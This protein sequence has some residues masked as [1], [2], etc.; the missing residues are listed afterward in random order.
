MTSPSSDRRNGLNSSMA[1]KVP[2]TAATTVNI[3]LNGEQTID[4][5]A[6]VAGTTCLV[7]DQSDPVENGIY[8][9]DTGDWT[10]RPDCDGPNDLTYGTIVYVTVG[11]QAGFFI[12]DSN[13]PV[14]GVDPIS[15]SMASTVLAT[16][17]AY[18]QT[19]LVASSASNAFAALALEAL[20]FGG[21]IS[22]TSLS[23]NTN[24]W[25]PT[26]FDTCSVIRMN[27]TADWNLTG[28][29]GG[30]G[31]LLKFLHNISTSTVTLKN[32]SANSSAGN[33]IK[34][35]AD[36][37]LAPNQS[38][39]LQYDG[40]SSRWRIFGQ[41]NSATVVSAS[42]NRM[43][44]N[45]S[46]SITMAASAVTI[47]LKDADG[48][49]PSSSSV[50]T[51]GFRDSGIALGAV[52]VRQVTAALSTA[53]SSGSTG[54]TV[55]TVPSRIWIAAIDNAGTVELAWS[56]RVLTATDAGGQTSLSVQGFDEG[57]FISTTAEGGAGA[58]D[59][60]QT[61]YS[62]TARA[63]VAYTILGYF[64]STQA[65]AGTWASGAAAVVTNPSNRPG[66]VLQVP[67]TETGVFATGATATPQDDTIPLITEG[68]QTM[69]QAI[70]PYGAAN[71]LETEHLG[72][73][74]REAGA[75]DTVTLALFQDAS[76]CLA[77]GAGFVYS[78]I[79]APAILRH[80]SIAGTT[81]ATTMKT[82]AGL[83]AG[84]MDFNGSAGGRFYGG[85]FASQMSV[86]EIS[87]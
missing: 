62:T 40:T 9:V 29:A 13:D 25:A 69:T 70:T 22:P 83:A 6:L 87:A 41:Q 82:R 21:V 43:V 73:Y 45:A 12:Q 68:N 54:G 28:I 72:Y 57:T 48:N 56:Q 71:I 80:R 1:I 52:K 8:T 14:P 15:F 86:K 81:A 78:S 74:S 32:E 61:W 55:S 60:A 17:S 2:V 46:L 44:N 7:K 19:V 63:N 36:Y 3:T 31:G 42:T 16:V 24:N 66:H 35:S 30:G 10:R 49:T 65:V 4:G 5:N 58:A 33:R 23:A 59:S 76:A 38:V 27:A 39:L 77:V 79:P 18:M 20:Y 53:I 47:A 34:L 26:G 51:I 84:T 85:R 11:S 37:A 75:A 64:D 67:C 50:A